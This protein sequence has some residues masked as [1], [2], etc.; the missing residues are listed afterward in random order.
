M[1]IEDPEGISRD[2]KKNTIHAINEI[3]K[4][5]YAKYGDPEILTRI[6]QYEMAYRMQIAVPEVMNINNEPG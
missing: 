1:Y 6:N 3:N 5:E 2:L 4:K